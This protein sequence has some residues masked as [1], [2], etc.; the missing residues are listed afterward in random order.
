M[1]S[2]I[3][4]H[5]FTQLPQNQWGHLLVTQAFMHSL[6]DIGAGN[7]KL[8]LRQ[9]FRIQGHCDLDP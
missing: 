5:F 8:L 7:A 3:F 9:A 1:L 6:R 4:G 2:G